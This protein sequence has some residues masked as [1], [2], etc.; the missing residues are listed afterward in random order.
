MIEVYHQDKKVFIV[1][2]ETNLPNYQNIC[3]TVRA[4]SM[5]L[6]QEDYSMKELSFQRKWWYQQQWLGKEFLGS[7]L[8]EKK[9]SKK[10]E[11]LFLEHLKNE[12]TPSLEQLCPINDFI[13]IREGATSNCVRKVPNFLKERQF[14]LR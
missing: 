6:R 10:S 12:M 7:F 8:L 9:R 5:V 14:T 2:V 13:L 1:H 11:N 3:V 4:G